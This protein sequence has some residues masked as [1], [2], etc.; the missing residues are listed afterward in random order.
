MRRMWPGEL[1]F[2]FENAQEVMLEIP[3]ALREEKSDGGAIHHKA[4][5]VR[6]PEDVC[7]QLWPLAE[8]RYRLD[9]KNLGKAV[10]LIANNPHYHGV[11][12]ADGGVEDS[13]SDSGKH[14]TTK[15][16]VVHFLLDDV[17]EPAEAV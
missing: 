2:V 8:A 9:G 14:Y 13:V 12:P 15:Y 6:L 3:V 17:R 1:N 16:L 10:T 11:H 5:K 4:L 7:A